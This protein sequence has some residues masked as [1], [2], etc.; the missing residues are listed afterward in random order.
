MSVCLEVKKQPVLETPSLENGRGPTAF[1]Y[2]F[3]LLKAF[4]SLFF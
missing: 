1:I 2:L 4:P 3:F